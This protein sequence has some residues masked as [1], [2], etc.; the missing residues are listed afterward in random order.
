MLRSRDDDDD[1]SSFTIAEASVAIIKVRCEPLSLVA[2]STVGIHRHF[3][4]GGS[5]P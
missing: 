5:V 4:S 3:A 2:G 1:P